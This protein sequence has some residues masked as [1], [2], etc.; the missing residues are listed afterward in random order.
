MTIQAKGYTAILVTFNAEDSV[1]EALSAI[2]FQNPPPSEIIVIDDC[3]Q[4]RTVKLIQGFNSSKNVLQ[5]IVN[6]TNRGQSYSRNIAASIATHPVIIFFDDDDISLPCRAELH[7]KMI[8]D[9]ADISY[10]SSKKT[11]G[12]SYE[13]ENINHLI[14]NKQIDTNAACG[15]IFSGIK[16]DKKY[17]FSVPACTLG[18][19]TEVF[20]VLGG[21]DVE[22]RRLEDVGL[23]LRAC[24]QACLFSWSSSVG[25]IRRHSTGND[26]G[27]TLDSK[28]EILLLE[29][30]RVY[31]SKKVYRNAKFIAELR[32][33]YFSGSFVVLP[34]FLLRNPRGIFVLL[35]RLGSLARRLKHDWKKS[36][37]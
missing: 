13:V 21:F 15:Y 32:R 1:L 25:V 10:V 14:E 16:I 7:L 11:Y 28:Y 9:G 34:L 24:E 27:G 23:F 35:S 20:N 37:I 19:K 31:L 22:M 30:Y 2:V 6:D 18:I 5:L 12:D 3:S 36:S 4:D 8:S 17:V 33:I 26:K 29:R